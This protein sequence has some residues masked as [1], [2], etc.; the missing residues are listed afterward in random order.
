MKQLFATVMFISGLS[1]AFSQ[2]STWTAASKQMLVDNYLRT[3]QAINAETGKLS[4]AQWNFKESKD[5]WNIAMVLEHLNTWQ[6]VTQER[7]RFMTDNG[8]Q[9][10]YLPSSQTDSA[11]TKT[12][13]EEQKHTSPP[14]SVPTGLVPDV[15]NLK[16]FNV[17]CD[18]ILDNIRSSQLNFKLYFRRFNSGYM[19]NINQAYMIHYLHVDRHLRQI[20]RIK[21]D[22]KF[23]K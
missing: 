22:P 21:S 3:Q 7:V 23:P 2:D 14:F 9:P 15:A 18:R 5:S 6:I 13:Q 11:A 20:R 17:Y 12:I 1:S 10:G 4:L 8:P 16:L 19:T